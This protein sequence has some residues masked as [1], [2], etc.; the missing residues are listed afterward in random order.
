MGKS[1]WDFSVLLAVG[2]KCPDPFK[3]WLQWVPRERNK[4]ADALVNECN[5]KGLVEEKT[6]TRRARL[7]T[8]SEAWLADEADTAGLDTLMR[9]DFPIATGN[10]REVGCEAYER[11]WPRGFLVNLVLVVADKYPWARHGLGGPWRL[12]RSWEVL[13]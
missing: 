10:L 8:A 1:I 5:M 13:H 2:W 11:S 7:L 4:R 12:V 9:R 6:A 3:G